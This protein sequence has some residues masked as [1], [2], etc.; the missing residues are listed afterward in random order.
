[1]EQFISGEACPLHLFAGHDFT[2]VQTLKALGLID[3]IKPKFGATLTFEL[4]KDPEYKI[5]VFYHDFV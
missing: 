1:M 3:T 4:H 2:L 5:K